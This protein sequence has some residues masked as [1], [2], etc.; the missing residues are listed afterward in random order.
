MPKLK[1]FNKAFNLE[2]PRRDIYTSASEIELFIGAMNTAA[3]AQVALTKT[4]DALREALKTLS[5]EGVK[6]GR[7]IGE[8][9]SSAPHAVPVLLEHNPSLS[10]ERWYTVGLTLIRKAVIHGDDEAAPLAAY[11]RLAKKAKDDFAHSAWQD[12]AALA[13][14][15][16]TPILL[17][18]VLEHLPKK[19]YL[20]W[21][22]LAHTAALKGDAMLDA[23]MHYS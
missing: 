21:E 10:K 4:P 6:W 1:A 2:E 14:E 19:K 7:L 20:D 16:R 18:L 9:A 8:M 23:V 5:P 12:W 17:V 11:L 13:C 22:E 3:I 15:A